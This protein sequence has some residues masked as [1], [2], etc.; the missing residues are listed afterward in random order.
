[1]AEDKE[2]PPTE[3]SERPLFTSA[4]E[5]VA[6]GEMHQ[7]SDEEVKARDRRNVAIAL[8]VVAFVVLVFLTTFLRLSENIANGGAG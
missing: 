6:T 7:P 4:R 2:T 5:G 8:G 3:T 1:M